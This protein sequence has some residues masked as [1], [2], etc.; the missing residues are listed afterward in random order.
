M[1]RLTGQNIIQL[2]TLIR[3]NMKVYNADK[4]NRCRNN[5]VSGLHTHKYQ[6]NTHTHN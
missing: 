2:Y 5:G 3:K 1:D 6:I 4:K